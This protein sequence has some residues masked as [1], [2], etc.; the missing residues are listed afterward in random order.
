[1]VFVEKWP[2]FQ[3]VFLGTIG[4]ENV[5]YNILERRN[6]FPGSKTSSR[7]CRKINPWFWSENGHFSKNFFLG[8]IGQ[9][10]VV[11]DILQGKSNF[12]CYKNK[13][14]KIKKIDIF[15]KMAIFGTSW[16][17]PWFWSKNGN[18]SNILFFT[19]YRPEKRLLRYSRTKKTLL[20]AIKTRSLKSQKIDIFPQG[21]N[22][23][24]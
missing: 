19:Q 3:L 4:Q 10:N 14:Q 13:N 20:E 22:S 11:Y 21:V 1:M 15:P 23:W 18:F 2:F 6:A 16:V 5:F 8:N 17:M 7:K 9:E 12:L 24:F